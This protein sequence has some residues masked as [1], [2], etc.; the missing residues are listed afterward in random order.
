MR[1]TIMEM[2]FVISMPTRP[3]S[4]V[5][6]GLDGDLDAEQQDEHAFMCNL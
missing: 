1:H 6:K 4:P 2:A 3:E 5:D